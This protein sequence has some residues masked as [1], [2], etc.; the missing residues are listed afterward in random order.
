MKMLIIR[1]EPG[2]SAS[3][4]RALESGFEPLLLPF[5]E[6]RPRKWTAP[7]PAS[8]DALLISSSNAVR[9]GGAALGKLLSLPVVAVG[10]RS[11][12][13]AQH[14]GFIIAA[15]GDDGIEAGL[16]KADAAGHR[17]LL[18]L[19]GEDRREP[20]VPDGMQIDTE[21]IY[22]S[23]VVPLPTNAAETI[24][25]ADIVAL[26]S[27]RAAQL[28]GETVDAIGLDR[29]RITL[30]AFS[31]AIAQTVGQGWGGI[32]IAKMPEDQALLSA[33]AELGKQ[34]Q[35]APAGKS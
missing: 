1:P 6:V 16:A 35:T 7:D 18:W 24:A 13:A 8:Y 17:R 30:V 28:F 26:H 25:S 19:A 31:A 12:S 20:A 34:H 21:V 27:P 23:E 29:S 22:A 2:A 4:K 10:K 9:H 3:A 11:A 32:A 33:A 15:I 14:Q 5:F